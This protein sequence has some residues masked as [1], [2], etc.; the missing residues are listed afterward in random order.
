[1]ESKGRKFRGRTYPWGVVEGITHRH[2]LNSYT[3]LVF[4]FCFSVA[5]S[6]FYLDGILS[7]SDL[8]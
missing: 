7:V 6:F 8:F 5:L 3:F 4:I 1:M 2:I